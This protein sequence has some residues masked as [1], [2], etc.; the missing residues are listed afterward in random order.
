[1][2]ALFDSAGLAIVAYVEVTGS[3]GTSNNQNSGVT[4]SR[5]GPGRYNI[6][7]PAGKTQNQYRDLIFVQLLGTGTT[8]IGTQVDD[9]QLA[10]PV[11][12]TQIKSIYVAGASSLVDCDFSVLILRTLVPPPTNV[13]PG[14]APA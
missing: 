5:L 2:N 9:T 6:I 10:D 3:D 12:G 13:P 8:A 7:L 11:T 1:M 4:T 14:Y